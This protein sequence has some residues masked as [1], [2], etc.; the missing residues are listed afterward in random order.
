MNSRPEVESEERSLFLEWKGHP[1]TKQVF[2][3]LQDRVQERLDLWVSGQF[4]SSLATEYV[5]R[6]SAAKGY[7]Q[8]C[9]DMIG[10]SFEDVI[11]E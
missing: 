4:D 9:Q 10:I 8:A 2:Q 7:I 3:L 11:N 5:A 1:V 6:N